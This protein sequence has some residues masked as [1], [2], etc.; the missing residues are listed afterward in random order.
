MKFWIWILN[1][2][3]V[4]VASPCWAKLISVSGGSVVE[5]IGGDSPKVFAG[6]LQNSSFC[7][8]AEVSG[9]S[10]CNSCV[11]MGNLNGSQFA[12]NKAAVHDNTV[13]SVTLVLTTVP[14]TTV[15]VDLTPSSSSTA[16]VI[17][18]GV[19]SS[20]TPTAGAEFTVSIPWSSICQVFGSG[21]SSLTSEKR[22]TLRVGVAQSGSS[23]SIDTTASVSMSVL[24]RKPTSAS[25]LTKGS[26]PFSPQGAYYD[27]EIYPGD[28]KVYLEN[29]VRLQ[30]QPESG[31]AIYWK[32]IRLFASTSPDIKTGV[33]P[34][35]GK[36]IPINDV[37]TVAST[38]SQGSFPNLENGRE[39]YFT[40][41]TVDQTGNAEQFID[42]GIGVS[43]RATPS[44]V[45]GVLDGKGCFI[46]TAAYGSPW[47]PQVQVLRD[48]R[49]RF[50][51]T[52]NWGKKF[53]RF[54]YQNSPPWAQ[55]LDQNQTAKVVTRAF[56][57]PL[58]GAAALF[59]EGGGWFFILLVVA[60]SLFLLFRKNLR[61]A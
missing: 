24:L 55:W 38:L 36:D 2:I 52:N 46:A 33:N 13:L 56:L 21:C 22:G 27:F 51:L 59:L 3:L 32:A 34:A 47:A 30:T 45:V 42:S 61:R 19:S 25:F 60:G 44:E 28:G 6:L 58:V 15:I 57:W 35:D 14:S 31:G 7:T 26:T 9:T 53:V 12:C 50:L 11:Q 5:G 54:Y 29:P 49:D 41:A 37:E 1:L 16:T 39:Y 4:L 23:T 20:G 48:F 18:T 17:T 8:S 40:I 43:Q 10:T